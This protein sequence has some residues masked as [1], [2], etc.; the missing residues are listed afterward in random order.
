MGGY[1]RKDVETKVIRGKGFSRSGKPLSVPLHTNLLT[2]SALKI[3]PS[4]IFL[5]GIEFVLRS[6]SMR[7]KDKEKEKVPFSERRP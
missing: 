7:E 5:A 2:G 4:S 3:P 1:L 6:R